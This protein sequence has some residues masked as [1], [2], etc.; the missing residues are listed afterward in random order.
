MVVDASVIFPTLVGVFPN[1]PCLSLKRTRWVISLI[2][3]VPRSVNFLPPTLLAV[4]LPQ[5]QVVH[6]S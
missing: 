5:F 1:P 2:Q 3:N 4:E 6:R